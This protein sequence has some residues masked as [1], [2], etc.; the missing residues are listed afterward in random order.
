MTATADDVLP[1]LDQRPL[2]REVPNEFIGQVL[3]TMGGS[4]QH[5]F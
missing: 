4:T 3:D 5:T 2:P 1:Q